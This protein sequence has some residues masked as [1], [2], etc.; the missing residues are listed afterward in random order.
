MKKLLIA[1]AVIVLIGIGSF[2]A[3]RGGTKSDEQTPASQMSE[4]QARVA[5]ENEILIKDFKFGPTNLKIKKG[6][7]VTWTNLDDARHDISPTEE[8]DNFKS[9]ELL[10]KDQSYTFTFNQ[11]GTYEYNCS[12]HPYMK[13]TVEVTE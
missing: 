7:T 10:S 2:V 8:S 4:S 12:P 1:A 6:T 3:M 5:A 9:S 11:A 13:G